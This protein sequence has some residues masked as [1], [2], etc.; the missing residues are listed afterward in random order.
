[1]SARQKVVLITGASSG[2]GFACA[3]EFAKHGYL[4]FAGARRLQ[5]MQQLAAHNVVPIQLDVSSASS[6]EAA[7]TEIMHTT[8]HAFLD[9]LFNNAGQ[10]CTFPAIDVA[11]DVLQQCFDVN[12]FGAVRAT[13]IFSPLLINA[14]GTVGFTGSVTL[15]LSPPWLSVYNASKAALASYAA[16]LRLE[17][18]PFDVTVIHIVTGGVATNIADTRSLP[19]LSLYNIPP[20]HSAFQYRQ[21][22]AKLN[23][24]MPPS[25]FA[26]RVVHD[27]ITA[28]RRNK[29]DYYRGR[30]LLTLYW[31]V[32]L[33]P[34][35]VV[36]W[37]L[38]RKFKLL[39]VFRALRDQYSNSKKLV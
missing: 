23:N 12:L 7:K 28:K 21:E 10:S 39:A 35:R 13:R 29:L 4:V 27:F 18:R 3:I 34:R 36:E 8:G 15:F 9:V 33:F 22:M 25:L 17:L 11:D 19:R 37:G 2:I 16:T 20:M 26:E 31:I 5:P 14:K 1:M 38:V 30:M 6:L 24:P 32:K